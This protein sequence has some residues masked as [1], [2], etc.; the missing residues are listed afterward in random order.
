MT[1]NTME[2]SNNKTYS[3]LLNFSP[4]NKALL[5]NSEPEVWELDSSWL[6]SAKSSTCPLAE[7]AAQCPPC[8]QL[9]GS[10]GASGDPGRVATRW[11]AQK[12]LTLLPQWRP[13]RGNRQVP[14]Q[15]ETSDI[16]FGNLSQNTDLGQRELSVL[17][18]NEEGS[19]L[20]EERGH[21]P[22]QQLGS[23]RPEKRDF[24]TSRVRPSMPGGQG[25]WWLTSRS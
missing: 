1:A 22:T 3:I 21:P 10:S 8:F 16:D 9:E 24:Q 18:I 12:S 15:I 14:E 23:G 5:E 19:G 20:S 4:Q 6:L 25:T 11:K 13:T 17:D 2:K 7:R